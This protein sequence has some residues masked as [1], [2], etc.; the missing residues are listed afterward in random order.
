MYLAD[1]MMAK[2][3]I[4]RK[5]NGVIEVNESHFGNDWKAKV[6]NKAKSNRHMF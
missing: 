5:L 2:Q 1:H 4:T 6:K 3:E